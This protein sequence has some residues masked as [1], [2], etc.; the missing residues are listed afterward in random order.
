MF[1]QLFALLLSDMEQLEH[2]QSSHLNICLVSGHHK[3]PT[4]FFHII[5]HINQRTHLKYHTSLTAPNLLVRIPC[6]LLSDASL[7]LLYFPHCA[8]APLFCL[9][10]LVCLLILVASLTFPPA[11]K[12]SI[13]SVHSG[14][15][16]SCHPPF[17]PHP[18][19]SYN[20]THHFC[21][22]FVVFLGQINDS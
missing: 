16:C 8:M 11:I 2:F 5:V 1:P 19:C 22:N 20:I 7:P 13:P 4:L 3:F 10:L 14:L 17:L 9:S 18:S 6:P 21:C 15:F 12:P